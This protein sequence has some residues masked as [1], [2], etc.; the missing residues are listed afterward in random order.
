MITS[1]I[2]PK[3][4]KYKSIYS[5]SGAPM[6]SKDKREDQELVNIGDHHGHN[7]RTKTTK[8]GG[9]STAFNQKPPFS[10]QVLAR[11]E[12]RGACP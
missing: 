3:K 5:F 4:Q 12:T 8:K 1:D 10:P 6:V 11:S 2:K 7:K 9:T